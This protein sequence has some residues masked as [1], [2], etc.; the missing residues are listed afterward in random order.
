MR[1]LQVLRK[2]QERFFSIETV[3]QRVRQAWP[4]ASPPATCELPAYGIRPANLRF[5]RKIARD[6]PAAV[7]HVTG[8]AHYV[9]LALP[10]SRTVL[11]IHDAVFLEQYQ[12]WKRWLLKKILLDIPVRY[13]RYVTTISEKSK[14]EIM[15]HT[16]CPAEKIR[17]IPNPV[18]ALLFFREQPFRQD[19]PR[20]LFIGITPNKNLERVCEAIKG[21]N[22][23]LVIIGKP[24]P[25][26]QALMDQ[27]RI[28][29]TFKH[30][31]P[32][33]DMAAQ[34]ADADVVLF[35]SLYEG[36]GLPVIE[37]F[38]AGRVVVTSNIPPMKDVSNGG[39]CLVD[40]YDPVSI[41][42]GLEQV[43]NDQGYRQALISR[44]FDVVRSYEPREIARQYQQVYLEIDRKACAE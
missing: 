30:G 17:V 12:G 3:F 43:I 16:R 37:G 32:E 25:Q 15:R 20:L 36:F 7:F 29:Y 24:S 38:R 13:S 19:S 27:H 33:E 4:D 41:R 28:S 8:D 1:V 22:C 5:A 14:Q 23:Q 42:K 35:P 2:K 21:L 18:S 40:P 44:G 26:Q 6:N 9:V 31:I 39:A 10:R 11:T 34:Y